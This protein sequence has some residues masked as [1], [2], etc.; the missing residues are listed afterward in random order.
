M[1]YSQLFA[2]SFSKRL[3]FVSVSTINHVKRVAMQKINYFELLEE[4]SV[5]CSRSVFLASGSTRALLQGALAENIKI[6]EEYVKRVSVLEEFLFTDFLPPLQRRSIAEAAHEMGKVIECSHR[7][8]TQRLQRSGYD[9]RSRESDVCI[10]LAEL[11]EESVGLLKK[12]KKPNQTPK[13]NEFRE[14]LI[15]SRKSAKI[16]QKRQGSSS[17]CMTEL[18]EELADCFDKIIEIM[19]CNI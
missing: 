11:I 1:R 2:F 8:I 16:L 19:L 12:I 18:R 4:I 9:K 7:V 15:T 3:L 14:I 17:L 5:L 6:Q 10:R 13:I